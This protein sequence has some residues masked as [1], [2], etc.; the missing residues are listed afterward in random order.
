MYD[1]ALIDKQICEYW[2]WKRNKKNSPEK[3]LRKQNWK[4]IYPKHKRQFDVYFSQQ[5]ISNY[6]IYNKTLRQLRFTIRLIESI[7]F[8]LTVDFV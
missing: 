6:F 8:R 1:D 3:N 7:F 2:R 4:K 5:N